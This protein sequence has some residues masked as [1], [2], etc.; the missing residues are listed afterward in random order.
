MAWIFN[1]SYSVQASV[2]V[3]VYASVFVY[4]SSLHL[5]VFPSVRYPMWVKSNLMHEYI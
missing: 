3:Y 5:Y 1:H 2:T 4:L